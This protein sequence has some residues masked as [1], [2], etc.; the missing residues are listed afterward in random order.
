MVRVG[1]LTSGGGC[2]GLNVAIRTIGETPYERPE[3]DVAI[4]GTRNGHHGLIEDDYWEMSPRDL[5]GIL[6]LGGAILD[7]SRQPF[8]EIRGPEGSQSGKVG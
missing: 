6:T 4:F 3:D 7:T 8:K 5:S 2:Q 1:I